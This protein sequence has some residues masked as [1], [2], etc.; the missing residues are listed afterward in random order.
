MHLE[1]TW[2]LSLA[3]LVPVVLIVGAAYAGAGV[4]G[5][6]P[7]WRAAAT[8]TLLAVGCL[9]EFVAA[10]FAV[11]RMCEQTSLTWAYV[12]LGVAAGVVASGAVAARLYG[13]PNRRQPVRR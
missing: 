10:G 8:V 13:Y 7:W 12:H 1:G 3:F 5:L 4:G 6:E 11:F 9:V 2:A